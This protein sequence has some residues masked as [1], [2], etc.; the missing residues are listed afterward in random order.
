MWNTCPNINLVAQNLLILTIVTL[1]GNGLMTDR[2]H[3]QDL[4][5]N[6]WTYNYNS[7][8]FTSTCSNS[9]SSQLVQVNAV[10]PS[11]WM[12]GPGSS[13]EGWYFVLFHSELRNSQIC[14][15]PLTVTFQYQLCLWSNKFFYAD[16]RRASSSIILPLFYKGQQ[17]KSWFQLGT[18]DLL[19][20]A[21]AVIFQQT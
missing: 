21:T 12:H 18:C 19:P 13:G 6:V 20:K 9:R 16:V 3:F 7:L 15:I 17:P 2:Q 8:A 11:V 10:I 4:L 14:Q 1:G 5:W